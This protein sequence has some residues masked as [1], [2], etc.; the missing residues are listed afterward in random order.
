MNQIL[1]KNSFP[2]IL[3]ASLII[4]A[5]VGSY[6]MYS[7]RALDNT[8]SVTGSTKQRVT[9]DSARWGIDVERIVMDGDA[10]TGYEQVTA[11]TARV[12]KFLLAQNFADA[13]ITVAPI[14][15]SE[16]YTG[17]GDNQTKKTAVRQSVSVQTKQVAL[18]ETAAQKTLTLAQQ[19]MRFT[20]Q[21]PQYLISNLAEYRIS[22]IAK[23]VQDAQARAKE[24]AGSMGQRVGRMKSATNGVVQVMAPESTAVSDYGEYDTSTKEKDVMLTVRAVFVLK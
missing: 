20:A 4:A 13:D 16:Y 6:A 14:S 12:K 19:G 2:L 1:E 5:I 9:A 21:Q 22:L 18:V 23:A 10:A 11:D 7:V 24:L 8:L 3:G 15:T 17:S